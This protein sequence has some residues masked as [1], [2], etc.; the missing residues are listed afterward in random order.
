MIGVRWKPARRRRPVQDPPQ[1]S[2][3]QPA[4]IRAI[5]PLPLPAARGAGQSIGTIVRDALAKPIV[6]APVLGLLFS[7]G[8]NAR[9]TAAVAE[10]DRGVLGGLKWSSQHLEGGSCDDEA[11]AEFGSVW[12]GAIVLTRSPGGGTAR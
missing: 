12:S 11:Q 2:I 9:V 6:I 1:F 10:L 5:I 8:G 4:A 7:L 3:P